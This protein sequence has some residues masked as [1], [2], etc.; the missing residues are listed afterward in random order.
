ML[1]RDSDYI[2]DVAMWPKLGNPKSYLKEVIITLILQ[3][4]WG[5]ILIQVQ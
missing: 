2:I 4:F 1:S 5:V 3:I